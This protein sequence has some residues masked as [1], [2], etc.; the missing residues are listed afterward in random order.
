MLEGAARGRSFASGRG[1]FA[2]ARC[3]ACHRLG[4]GGGSSGPDLTAA[5]GRFSRRD[6]LESIVLPSKVVSDQF[7][8]TIYVRTDGTMVSGRAVR[9]DADTLYVK[10]DPLQEAVVAIIKKDIKTF[11]LSPVS[12]MPEGLIDVLTQDEI[13]DL[14]AYIQSA[15]KPDHPAFK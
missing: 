5:A 13:L 14:I 3:A 6:L 9:E 12:P 15:G 11:K 2:K 10:P 4:P 1:A 8:N 7:Q